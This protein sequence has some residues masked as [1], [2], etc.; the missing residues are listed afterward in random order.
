MPFIMTCLGSL[1]LLLPI[2]TAVQ[3]SVGSRP[4]REGTSGDP[5]PAE[6][7][8]AEALLGRLEAAH[9]TVTAFSSPLTYRK[10]YALEGDH[11][12][13]VG[14]VALRGHGPDRE[15]VLLFDLVIDASGHGTNDPR[16]H[17]YENGWWTE[18]DPGRKQLRTRQ[19]R[20]AG[21][22]RDP[23]DLGEGPLPLPI[24]QTAARVLAL[25]E[26]SMGVPPEDPI[27]RAIERPHVLHLVPRAG[28]PSADDVESI[29]LLYDRESLL[30]VGL[31]VVDRSGDRTTAWLRDPESSPDESVFRER[32][33]EVRSLIDRAGA[34]PTWTIDR[35]PL[36]SSSPEAG[37]RP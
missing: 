32:A 26:V 27:L 10:E 1:V 15:I 11:E 24:G 13:R 22:N 18:I 3:D 7:D 8:S 28:T 36:A 4:S 9:A 29:D 14:R 12:T 34:D 31:L 35:K 21:S 17:V 5:V 2:P 20:K 6:V 37:G 19:I 25:F 30:P 16:Y 33:A 23:F